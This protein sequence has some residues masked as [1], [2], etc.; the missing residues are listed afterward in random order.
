MMSKALIS[1]LK[2]QQ[3]TQT[4]RGFF[5]SLYGA[6]RASSHAFRYT[7]NPPE[8]AKPPRPPKPRDFEDTDTPFLT[9]AINCKTMP[10]KTALADSVKNNFVR[11]HGASFAVVQTAAPAQLQAPEINH[12]LLSLTDA[13]AIEEVKELVRR[14]SN[15]W[16]DCPKWVI[17]L[18][19][20]LNS[21]PHA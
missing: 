16:P 8:K 7:F 18:S 20:Q 10:T 19:D 6:I 13:K 9:S 14:G 3:A 11:I 15:T 2:L 17:N 5:P 21:F 4:L 12:V 1:R